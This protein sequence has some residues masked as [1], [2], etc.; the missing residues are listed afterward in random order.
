MKI[1]IVTS[2]LKIGGIGV[3]TVT[4]ANCLK[5]R[6]HE[7][8]VASS[9]GELE[10]ELLPEISKIRISLSAKS[11]LNPKV[12]QAAFK[13]R[14]LVKSE[15]IEIMHAQTR[16]AQFASHLVSKKTGVPYVVTWHGFYRPH[17]FR[18]VL[19]FWGDMTIAISRTVFRNLVDVFKREKSKVRLIFNGVDTAKFRD[20]YS[21]TQKEDIRN[22]YGLGKG[23]VVGI[24]S[25]LSPE[26]GHTY[27]LDAFKDLLI[28]I[29]DAQLVIV[30]GGRLKAELKEKSAALG[31]EKSVYFFGET[32]K[33]REFLAIMDVF[34]RPS[35]REGFGLGV[36]EAML[37][38][39]PVVSTDVGGF[40]SILDHGKLGFLVEP[41]NPA[42]LREAL[43]NV[44]SDRAR[45]KEMGKVG[46]EYAAANF[47]AE[48]MTAQV[49]EVY[50][51]VLNEAN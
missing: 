44:L 18:K 47:S 35:I 15:G 21:Q 17:F 29:P 16:V 46:K 12:W 5:R 20:D 49:E 38:G 51:E 41:R 1:L 3:Y 24:I 30:G 23:P 22:K 8:F 9:G 36:V 33:T 48:K 14:N 2:H 43:F 42:E 26:K 34:T 11:V 39:L 4:L 6:G 31:I 37:M 50:K 27:L 45:A 7:V 40:K 28:K 13:L 10:G 32:L 19:P 25:R